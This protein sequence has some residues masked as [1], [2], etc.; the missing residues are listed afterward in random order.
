[1]LLA[2]RPILYLEAAVEHLKRYGTSLEELNELLQEYGYRLFRNVGA[3]NGS[4]DE[5]FVQELSSLSQ[6]GGFFDVLA[7][8]QADPRLQY[9]TLGRKRRI[10]LGD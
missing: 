8:H 4:H 10:N 7:L 6:G 2:L 9:L 5:F 1:V 3:R